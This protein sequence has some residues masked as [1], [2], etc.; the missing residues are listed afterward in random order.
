MHTQ[1]WHLLLRKAL[2][3][4]NECQNFDISPEIVE[5]L[6]TAEDHRFYLHSGFDLIS[7]TRAL[8][9]TASKRSIEGGSTI[10]M[11]LV[12]VLTGNYKR[13][14]SRK[15]FEII[16]AITLTKKIGR[17]Q[18]P[19][20]YLMVAYF[21]WRMNGLIQV[22]ERLQINLKQIGEHQAA[23]IIARLKYPEGKHPSSTRI[24]QINRRSRHILQTH[25]NR[26]KLG[27]F[28]EPFRVPSQLANIT[29]SYPNA[30][31]IIEAAQKGGE[32]SRA[33]IARLWLSEGI[34]YAFREKPALYE[35]VRSWLSARLDINA[36]DVHLIGS[37]RIGQSLAPNKIGQVFGQH[38][39]L[40]IFIISPSLFEKMVDDFNSWACDFKSGK[41]TP[42]N[43]REEGYWRENIQRGPRNIAR[44]FVDSNITPNHNKFITTQIIADSMWRLKKK[45]DI[46]NG[47]PSVKKASIRCYRDW[48]S[49][50]RQVT[51]SL[52]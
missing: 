6:V 41:T 47:A 52:S 20:M 36:K 39:D 25:E 30:S 28:M 38:S 16:Y 12:R 2:T 26:K 31:E 34:P 27:D 49:F 14:L 43:V 40:D 50:V 29:G 1:E 19:K 8:W 32:Q 35:S 45:L 37:A 18:I 22:A 46:T 10:A 51:L 17:D 5:M 3:L 24:D 44:G 11:Q 33:A 42:S 15:L 4:K 7:F 13:T 21:G 48:G 9:R 23:D